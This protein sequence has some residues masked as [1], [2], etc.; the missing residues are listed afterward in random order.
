MNHETVAGACNHPNLLVLPFSFELL[1][2]SAYPRWEARLHDYFRLPTMHPT[3]CLIADKIVQ[4]RSAQGRSNH[5]WAEVSFRRAVR[6]R[7]A[8]RGRRKRCPLYVSLSVADQHTLIN[9]ATP[10]RVPLCSV[11]TTSRPSTGLQLTTD[12]GSADPSSNGALTAVLQRVTE[13]R[14]KV[15]LGALSLSPGIDVMC[16]WATSG[17]A[18]AEDRAPTQRDLTML[19]RRSVSEGN[20]PKRAW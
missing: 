13:N 4:E 20:S 6:L 2:H 8:K 14:W 11:R 5:A 18:A 15:Y 10:F 16:Q 3:G 17:L 9:N 7:K 19:P 12:F 1:R